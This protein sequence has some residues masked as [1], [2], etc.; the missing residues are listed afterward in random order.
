MQV[1][2]IILLFVV[3]IPLV[4][5]ILDSPVGRALAKRVEK[6]ARPE[7]PEARRMEV[8]EAEVERLNREVNRLDEETAFLHKLLES[9][10]TTKGD[11]PPG[12]AGD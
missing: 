5:V 2:T 4:A 10:T 8:L 11:L 3:L 7:V 1:I 12:Q 9:R 6:D